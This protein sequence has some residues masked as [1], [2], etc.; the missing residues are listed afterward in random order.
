MAY[1]PRVR[2]RSID[3]IE[4]AAQEVLREFDPDALATLKAFDVEHFFDHKLKGATKISPIIDDELPKYLDGYTDSLN[5]ECHIAERLFDHG[6][7]IV[8]ERRLRSTIA[9]ELG[10]CFLHV[11]EAR[12][13]REMQQ[14]FKQDDTCTIELYNPDEDRVYTHPEWQAWRFASSLLMPEI[15]FRRAIEVNRTIRQIQNTFEVN[16]AFVQVRLRELKIGKLLRR[17]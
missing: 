1:I 2:A 15:C 6:H 7:N 11:P 5:D 10:H 3:D 8:I 13:N 4:R 17:G 9:H 12:S 16:Y 14:V